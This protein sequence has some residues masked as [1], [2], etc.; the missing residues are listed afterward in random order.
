MRLADVELL[1]GKV[2]YR[3]L[4]WSL[5][6]YLG[7]DQRVVCA[8]GL[9][10]P[11]FERGH[12]DPVVLVHGFGADKE[13][14][15]LMAWAMSRGRRVIIPD[16][17]GHGAATTISRRG[18]SA[19]AQAHALLAFLDT[20]GVNRFHLVGNSMGGGISLRLADEQ[21]ERVRSLVLIDS[22]GPKVDPSE[23]DQLFERG[24][25]PLIPTTAAEAAVIMGFVAEKRS[26]LPR[27]IERHIIAER[28]AAAPLLKEIFAGWQ[29][30]AG[31]DGIPTDLERLRV[32]T[33]VIHGECDRVIDVSTGRELARR[34][35]KARLHV[36]PGVGHIP[37]VEVPRETAAAVEK[38][39]AAN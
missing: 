20:L 5:A 38:F 22:A 3:S 11:Y 24:E 6:R 33:L 7:L 23:L 14:W 25:N 21:P 19:R 8:E 18:A 34:I 36:M 27:A 2:S 35:P 9:S 12:G 17:P 31:A 16:L 39:V 10:M 28:V 13:S 32:P 29:R 1:V 37:Q 15:L 4:L 26:K 30:G